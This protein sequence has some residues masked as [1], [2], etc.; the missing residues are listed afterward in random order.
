MNSPTISPI[1]ADD[2]RRFTRNMMTSF[3]QIA[4]LVLLVGYCAVI[5]GPFA[6][7]IVWA[8][9]LAVAVYP[10]HLK[11]AA[12]LGGRAKWSATIITLAGLAIL[13]LPGWFVVDSTVDTAQAAARWTWAKAT[14]AY[15]RPTIPSK[16][17]R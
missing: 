10:L 1:L 12:A 15:R 9:I 6:T 8:I 3:I 14:C 4:A 16:A 2:E 13:L 11:L 7:I 5:I 17:G